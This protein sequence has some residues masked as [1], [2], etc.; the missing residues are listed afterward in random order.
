[1]WQCGCLDHLRNLSE[2]SPQMDMSAGDTPW[3]C[4][5]DLS[6]VGVPGLRPVASS[7]L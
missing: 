3:L 1:M 2:I 7:L 4:F 6:D 5:V